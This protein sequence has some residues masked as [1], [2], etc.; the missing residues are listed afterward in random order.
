MQIDKNSKNFNTCYHSRDR[1]RER[2]IVWLSD[3]AH[4]SPLTAFP[5]SIGKEGN[6]V[7]SSLKGMVDAHVTFCFSG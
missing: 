2:N 5:P 3:T 6:P 1:R 7:T 4:T